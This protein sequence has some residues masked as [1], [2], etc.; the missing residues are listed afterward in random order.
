M[1]KGTETASEDD[2]QDNCENERSE[3]AEKMMLVMTHYEEFNSILA[4][5]LKS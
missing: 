1:G 5:R 4:Y 2:K 3:D